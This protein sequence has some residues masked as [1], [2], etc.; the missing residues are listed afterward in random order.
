MVGQVGDFII[1]KNK[2]INTKDFFAQNVFH[3]RPLFLYHERFR[4]FF[5]GSKCEK[6]ETVLVADSRANISAF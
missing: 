3:F 6:T 5:F 4:S 1:G 2:K